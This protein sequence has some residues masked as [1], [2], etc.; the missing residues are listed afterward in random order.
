MTSKHYGLE[1]A[2]LVSLP[3]GMLERAFSIVAHLDMGRKRGQQHEDD[4]GEGEGSVAERRRLV[5][6]VRRSGTWNDCE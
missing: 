4:D 5:H 6:E 1:L 3:G 2:K